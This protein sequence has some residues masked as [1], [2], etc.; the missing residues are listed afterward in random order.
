MHAAKG[1]SPGTS[2]RST[3]EIAAPL[4]PPAPPPAFAPARESL[5]ERACLPA[6]GGHGGATDAWLTVVS[7]G[8]PLG[9]FERLI[10]RQAS[11]IVGLELMRERV[12]RETERRLAGDLLADALGDRL[13]A[14]EL[15]GR[16][17]PFG[18]GTRPRSWSSSC[19][20][21]PAAEGTLEAA[22]A[23][24]GVPALVA[25]SAA[26]G[27]PLLCAVVDAGAVEPIG[28]RA[29]CPRGAQRA[30]GAA[31]GS[32]PPPAGRRRR[33]CGGPSTGHAA[34]SRPPRWPTAR[35]RRSPP[36]TT[37]AHSR[38]CS[39]CRTRTRCAPTA[40]A[41]WG[42]SSRPRETTGTNCC[43]A[44]P[45]HR[46]QRP[47]GEGRAPFYRHRHTL[48][49]RIRQIEELTGR[50]LERAPTGS[51]SGWRCGGGSS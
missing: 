43:V 30:D 20:D 50:D 39:P 3:E 21:P 14:E 19:H 18:I 33:G 36:T 26:A 38:C 25:T 4:G 44:R 2:K 17:R 42:R 22:L 11:I 41:C 1:S 48:R 12:V 49:Y 35:G 47:L 24:A 37:S 13:D 15:R 7:D 32:A 6:P 8:R 34:P 51:S 27:R 45:L 28:D 9:D 40:G 23:D 10:A 5:A 31:T 46:E 29:R 16:L